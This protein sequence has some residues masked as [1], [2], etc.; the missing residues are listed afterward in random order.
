LQLLGDQ[1]GEVIAQGAAAGELDVAV[2][3]GFEVG[4]QGLGPGFSARLADAFADRD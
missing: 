2:G 4:A 1:A 3:V